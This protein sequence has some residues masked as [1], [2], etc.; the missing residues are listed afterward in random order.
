MSDLEDEFEEVYSGIESDIQEA[1]RTW[2]PEP[3]EMPPGMSKLLN[4]MTEADAPNWM[5]EKALDGAYCDFVSEEV[6]P[7]ALLAQDAQR[8]GLDEIA[9]KAVTGRYDDSL[10]DILN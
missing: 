6:S 9:N 7:K 10:E 8:A 2:S 5:F 3:E 1:R 4:D